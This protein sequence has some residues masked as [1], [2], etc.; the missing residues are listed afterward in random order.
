MCKV[1]F[2]QLIMAHSYGNYLSQKREY[3]HGG[4]RWPAKGR[5]FWGPCLPSMSIGGDIGS[6]A[7]S[8][9]VKFWWETCGRN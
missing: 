2:I 1:F 5:F 7:R 3:R 4:K 6:K 9:S 8:R